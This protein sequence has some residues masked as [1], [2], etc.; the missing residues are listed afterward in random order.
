[1]I[2]QKKNPI[3]RFLTFMVSLYKS[4]FEIWNKLPKTAIEVSGISNLNSAGQILK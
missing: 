3:F 2:A 1:V 4:V